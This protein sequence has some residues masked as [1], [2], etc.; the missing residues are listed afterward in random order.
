MQLFGNVLRPGGI[1]ELYREKRDAFLKNFSGLNVSQVKDL[2]QMGVGLGLLALSV[3]AIFQG[4]GVA[5]I[6]FL[7]PELLTAF[8]SQVLTSL[9]TL[10]FGAIGLS[11]MRKVQRN[12]EYYMGNHVRVDKTATKDLVAADA[13]D[14]PVA[15]QIVDK[16]PAPS[17]DN[18]SSSTPKNKR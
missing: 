2:F 11:G 12:Y 13:V 16:E 17:V 4:W 1:K 7:L 10:L 8:S 6:V 9:T 3:S 18:T 5:L 14:I 15:S